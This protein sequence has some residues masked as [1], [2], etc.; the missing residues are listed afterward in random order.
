MSEGY[1]P[2]SYEGEVYA[3]AAHH[4]APGVARGAVP[5]DPANAQQVAGRYSAAEA[6]RLLAS[7]E[8]RSGLDPS[9]H[10]YRSRPHEQLISIVNDAVDPAS[11][12]EQG[13]IANDLGNAQKQ[14]ADSFRRASAKEEAEWQGEGAAKAHAFFGALA[15]WSD[16]S[17]N[18]SH[19]TSNRLSQQSATLIQAKNNMPE[20][21]G[22][23]VEDSIA[24]A[25]Q[26]AEN[27]DWGKQLGVLANMER[28]ARLRQEAHERAAAVVQARDQA[29]YSTGSTQPTFSSAPQPGDSTS[30]S[31][32]DSSTR[33]S[34][35][36]GGPPIS[37]PGGPGAPM[38]GGPAGPPP[39]GA[40]VAPG[41][42]TSSGAGPN[43]QGNNP[44]TQPGGQWGRP[45][46][47][48]GGG[49]GGAV[50]PG[51]GSNLGRLGSETTRDK[52]GRGFGST[53]RGGG[54]GSGSAG[55]RVT[56]GTGAPRGGMPA[57]R[58]GSPGTPAGPGRGTGAGEPGA[59]S[60]NEFARGGQGGTGARGAGAPMGA[61]GGGR[62]NKEE[63]KDHKRAEYLQE[64]DPNEYFGTDGVGKTVPPV[65]GETRG[66]ER[67]EQ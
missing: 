19:L 48:G 39:G 25:N 12:D 1:T 64:D 61:A 62:G 36:G 17:A 14:L 45:A 50:A 51:G 32:I 42:G 35:F 23:P 60:A 40:G 57:P 10:D 28:Q 20:P 3:D 24:Q 22:M 16:S 21:A 31:S 63:D 13:M 11:V 65:I 4:G 52:P 38:G 55:N 5:V 54:Y 30:P 44:T 43:P 6:E 15:D 18:A 26:H 49:M 59:R 47:S 2:R 34:G 56:G 37:A 41:P 66:G 7:Q 58:S 46:A 67:T 9:D 33:T 53:G 27:G 29:L 8:F